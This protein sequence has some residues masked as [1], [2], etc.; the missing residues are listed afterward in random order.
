VGLYV[1]AGTMRTCVPFDEDATMPVPHPII[2]Y[3]VISNKDR[4]EYVGDVIDLSSVAHWDGGSYLCVKT[5]TNNGPARFQHHYV[6]TDGR[7][8][9]LVTYVSPG[10]FSIDASPWIAD[11]RPSAVG[12]TLWVYNGTTVT[13]HRII[14]ASG[15]PSPWTV[16]FDTDPS[17]TDPIPRSAVIVWPVKTLVSTPFLPG[18]AVLTHAQKI[19]AGDVAGRNVWF[20]STEFGPTNWIAVDDA[21]VL[22]TSQYFGGDQNVR[23]LTVFDQNLTVFYENGAQLWAVDADPANHQFVRAVGG[24]G[25]L[26][27]D[28]V[29][30]IGGDVLYFGYGVFRS[31]SSVVVT[32][33]PK[34]SDVGSPIEPLTNQINLRTLSTA[35]VSVWLSAKRQY[36][37][38]FDDTAYVFLTSADTGFS[39]WTTYKLPFAV[40]DACEYEGRLY[41]RRGDTSEVWTFDPESPDEPGFA[42]QVIQNFTTLSETRGVGQLISIEVIQ[43]GASFVEILTDPETL[44]GFEV[45]DIDG[46]S[47]R[48][49]KILIPALAE[50]V[51]GKFS[52]NGPWDLDEYRINFRP[53]STL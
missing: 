13:A 31:L 32:G 34:E 47:T 49:N 3:D 35:P 26:A 18:P 36:V 1:I 6:P 53:G 4:D 52:G 5:S 21:G 24:A 20:S 45:G 7:K 29:S 25:T 14:T 37:T 38:F 19:W 16:S 10:V 43:R 8:S 51:A 41:V 46:T 9:T 48:Y 40:S 12:D 15:G 2:T 11:S 44:T 17:F 30:N 22:P 50:Y 33:Q 28:T 27:P 23:G 42:F 39:G